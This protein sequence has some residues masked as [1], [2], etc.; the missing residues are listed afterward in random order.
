LARGDPSE[1]LRHVR[2]DQIRLVGE[3]PARR[4]V[5][6]S[7]ATPSRRRRRTKDADADERL[8]PWIDLEESTRSMGSNAGIEAMPLAIRSQCKGLNVDETVGRFVW[9]PKIT[10]RPVCACVEFNQ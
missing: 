7:T 6:A 9:K 10:R 8:K 3:E 1:E 4:R 2:V 5:D